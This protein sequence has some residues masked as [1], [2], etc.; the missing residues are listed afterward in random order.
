MIR[1]VALDLDDTLLNSQL[2]ISPETAASIKRAMEQGV[3][4]TLATGRMYRSALPFALELGLDVPLVTYHGAL[5]K[6][7]RS[8]EVI[9]DWPVPLGPARDVVRLAK[10]FGFDINLYVDDELYAGTGHR[11]INAYVNL[12]KVPYRQ[13]PDL[14]DVL[15]KE[16]HKILLI[17]EEEKLDEFDAVL[18]K[19]FPGQLHIAKSKPYFLEITSAAGTKGHALDELTR[20]MGIS[21]QEVMAV[22]DS[23]NDLEML[24]FA[25]TGVAMGN[26]R[27]EIQAKADFVTLSNEENGVAAAINKFVLNN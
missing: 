25:G 4:V 8:K 23:Y 10:E 27:P 1:L 9:C 17:G 14:L 6:T 3:T 2:A 22:G 24:E 11:Y 12:A 7:S 5:V 16:P 15:H 13:V 19:Q 20:N 21:Q 18:R 26:A